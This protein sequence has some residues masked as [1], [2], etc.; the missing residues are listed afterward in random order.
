MNG[1]RELLR[2]LWRAVVKDGKQHVGTDQFG[3]NYY[4][5]PRHK[6]WRGQIIREKRLVEAVGKKEEDYEVGDIPTE[7][8]AWIRKK[9]KEPPTIEE[10]MK[11]EK[12]R[13][14]IKLKSREFSEKEKLLEAGE[15]QTGLGSPPGSTL[16]RGHASAQLY[17]KSEPSE[18]PT[19]TGQAFQPGSWR[20]RGGKD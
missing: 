14:D 18:D 8:E 12:Y 9:R 10:I 17:G 1:A 20:P 4:F 5:V 19:S 16:V 3:N 13:E 7:W 11:N 15:S 6:N 2:G